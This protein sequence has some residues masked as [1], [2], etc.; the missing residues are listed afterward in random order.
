MAPI[1]ILRA[2]LTVVALGVIA[3]S[4]D[5]KAALDSYI[6]TRPISTR[7]QS[8]APL[9]LNSVKHSILAGKYT[10]PRPWNLSRASCPDSCTSLGLNASTWPVY[11]NVD[12]L[13]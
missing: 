3:A 8:K 7:S 4:E 9:D 2:T 10:S 13:D 11:S 6:A 12:R 5:A 1:G